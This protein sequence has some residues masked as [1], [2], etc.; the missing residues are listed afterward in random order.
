M[1]SLGICVRVYILMF[2]HDMM[3]L[4]VRLNKAILEVHNLMDLRV[5][6]VCCGFECGNLVGHV[7]RAHVILMRIYK[8]SLH[9]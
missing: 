6:V 9:T 2:G 8:E 4:V 5:Y 3:T 7:S 1:L